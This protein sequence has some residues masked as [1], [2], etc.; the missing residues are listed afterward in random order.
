MMCIIIIIITL[1]RKCPMCVVVVRWARM[2]RR[3]AH[4]GHAPIRHTDDVHGTSSRSASQPCIS[5]PHPHDPKRNPRRVGIMYHSTEQMALE[6]T[7]WAFGQK[8]M[9]CHTQQKCIMLLNPSI[10]SVARGFPIPQYRVHLELGVILLFGERNQQ[11]TQ[12]ASDQ[13]K[14]HG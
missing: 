8:L 10:P 5:T 14:H 13:H 11:T 4:D 6:E 9:S 1:W 3:H 12:S 2:T 7:W